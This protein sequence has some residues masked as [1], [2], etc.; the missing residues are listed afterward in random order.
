MRCIGDQWAGPLEFE[1]GT[2]VAGPPAGPPGCGAPRAQF[3]YGLQRAAKQQQQLRGPT[4]GTRGPRAVLE[5]WQQ[6]GPVAAGGASRCPGHGTGWPGVLGHGRGEDRGR[7]DE[8]RRGTGTAEDTRS[9]QSKGLTFLLDAGVLMGARLVDC[10][11]FQGVL[12]RG[13]HVRLPA[14]VCWSVM[15]YAPR[16]FG[17]CGDFA[18]RF[19]DVVG[20][21]SE[22]FRMRNVSWLAEYKL[23]I[24]RY[25][26]RERLSSGDFELAQYNYLGQIDNRFEG[27]AALFYDCL[28]CSNWYVEDVLQAYE[29]EFYQLFQLV[30]HAFFYYLVVHVVRLCGARLKYISTSWDLPIKNF[31]ILLHWKKNNR[32]SKT[33]F[34][35]MGLISMYLDFPTPQNSFFISNKAWRHSWSRKYIWKLSNLR[36]ALNTYGHRDSL[37]MCDN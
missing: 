1:C 9:C 28:F 6:P 18:G 25:C 2:K 10:G 23:Y 15:L 8:H 27:L 24:W 11:P 37:L 29:H 20:R 32:E 5:D 31:G 13:E 26:V 17:C 16:L 33:R 34:T 22:I 7:E 21:G 19:A 3:G 14:R 30:P 35:Q 12:I 4:S 36:N